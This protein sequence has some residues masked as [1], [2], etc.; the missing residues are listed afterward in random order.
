MENL[1]STLLLILLALFQYLWFTVK[2]G[3]SRDKHGVSAPATTGNE[4]WDRLFRIQQNTMEQLI[5]FIPCMIIFAMYVSSKWVLI[6]GAVY[7]IGRQIYSMSYFK[8]PKTRTVGM[9]LTLLANALLMLGS[10]Y[11]VVRSLF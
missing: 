6:L 2:V 8:D 11:G 7:L 1:N 4:I 3:I 9:T 5:I 10:L